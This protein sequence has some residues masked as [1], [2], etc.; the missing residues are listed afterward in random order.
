MPSIDAATWRRG[1]MLL[2]GCFDSIC[3]AD[4]VTSSVG[5]SAWWF[6]RFVGRITGVEGTEPLIAGRHLTGPRLA[7]P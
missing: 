6:T 1:K 4:T 3:R 5:W 7:L 2:Q